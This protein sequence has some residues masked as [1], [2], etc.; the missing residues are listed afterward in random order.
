[1]QETQIERIHRCFNDGQCGDCA[2]NQR[3]SFLVRFSGK[4][5]SDVMAMC[6]HCGHTN[7]EEK[8][9]GKELEVSE[10]PKAVS[11]IIKKLTER[12]HE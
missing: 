9:Q 1:M 12:G 3:Y 8:L 7:Y 4:E 10:L 11:F 5:K 2:G 6:C